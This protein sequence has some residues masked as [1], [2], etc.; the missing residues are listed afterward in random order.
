M[1]KGVLVVEFNGES[2]QQAG[3]ARAATMKVLSLMLTGLAAWHTAT[4]EEAMQNILKWR[5][6]CCVW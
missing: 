5:V 1:M 4:V 6:F 3:L 2:L